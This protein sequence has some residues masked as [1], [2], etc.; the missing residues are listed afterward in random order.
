VVAA[1]PVPEEAVAV[2]EPAKDVGPD[3]TIHDD[4][5][6]P[7]DGSALDA[8]D[9]ATD[10][11]AQAI[12]TWGPDTAGMSDTAAA[13]TYVMASVCEKVIKKCDEQLLNVIP[14]GW[15]DACTNFLLGNADTIKTACSQ[16]DNVETTD[17]TI[18]MI[19]KAGPVMLK[20]CVDNYQCNLESILALI[21]VLKPFFEGQKP[22]V[23]DILGLVAKMCLP[24]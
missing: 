4:G 9:V 17:P 7:D 11:A 21:P 20:Q 13:C 16:L 5:S 22:Q 23:S 12:E 19:Q 8:L 6:A 1:D 15:L 2:P 14:D 24:Q 10:D 18:L 3:E